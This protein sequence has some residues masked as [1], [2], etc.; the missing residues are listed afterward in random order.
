MKKVIERLLL[1]MLCYLLIFNSTA[2]ASDIKEYFSNSGKST[3]DMEAVTSGAYSLLYT[4]GA[5]LAVCIL[6]TIAISYMVATPNKR[7][8]LKER[9]I[10]YFAGVIFLV[11]GLAFLRI[12][13]KAANDVGDIVRSANGG[14]GY[15]NSDGDYVYYDSVAQALNEATSLALSEV[16]AM[17][18][19]TLKKYVNELDKNVR[20]FEKM[21]DNQE[22]SP[23]SGQI[24]MLERAK[25]RLTYSHNRLAELYSGDN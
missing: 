10:Y 22:H 13:E 11:G 5:M 4:I 20:A 6:V 25:S 8:L 21:L 14:S 16:N 12:Y 18:Y 1:F 24:N 19:N 15:T 3:I 2:F 9:L 23:D 17:D 7:A